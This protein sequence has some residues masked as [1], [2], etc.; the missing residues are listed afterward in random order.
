MTVDQGMV[1][2]ARLDEP[3]ARIRAVAVVIPARDEEALVGRCLDSV[4]AAAVR[5]RARGIRVHVVL[6]AD[7]CRDGTAEVARAFGAEVIESAA[8]RVGAARA[9]GVAAALAAWDGADDE[10]WIACTD[11]DSVVPRA[12]ITSQL[13]LADAGADVVVGTVRPELDAL[14]PAQI[15]AWRATRVPGAANGH[16]HG[17]NLGVRAD[18][19][20]RAGGFPEVAEHEDVDLVARLRRTGVTITASAAG[21]VLTSGR[22]DGRTP[23]GYAGYLHVSLLA[24]AAE[25]AAASADDVGCDRPCVPVG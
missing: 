21:E 8:G 20:V 1:A 6:V 19:Y 11:A 9:R 17:A 10:L 18:A 23:G 5:A 25:R 12:W 24:R 2:A 16:V 4:E 22:R 3:A 15:A 13:A 14:S 7:D